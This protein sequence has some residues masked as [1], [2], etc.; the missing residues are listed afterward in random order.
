MD[1][2]KSEPKKHVKLETKQLLSDALAKAD[3]ADRRTVAA[4]SMAERFSLTAQ[5]SEFA[6]RNAAAARKR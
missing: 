3:R 1:C 6:S 4:M 5:L 2:M